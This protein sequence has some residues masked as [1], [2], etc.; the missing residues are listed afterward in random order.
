MTPTS[1]YIMLVFFVTDIQLQLY[2]KILNNT[3]AKADY[4]TNVSDHLLNLLL[5]HNGL[6]L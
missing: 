3:S 6:P 2:Q 1:K 5:K 4:V